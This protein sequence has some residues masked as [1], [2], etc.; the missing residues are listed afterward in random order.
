HE[1][2]ALR[3]E[4]RLLEP[5]RLC[6]VALQ[7]QRGALALDSGLEVRRRLPTLGDELL[8]VAERDVG[9]FALT[10]DRGLALADG[11]DLFVQLHGL[12]A[13]LADLDAHLLAALDRKS[14][15]LN[16]SH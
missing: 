3:R 12:L 5:Q 13:E 1:V 7:G 4:P 6:V 10:H 2:D 9:A 16:S 8:G 15:R 14:T 11:S